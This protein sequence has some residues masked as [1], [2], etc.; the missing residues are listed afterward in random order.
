MIE[1]RCERAE[2]APAIHEILVKAFGGPCEAGLV[3]LLRERKKAE[4]ALA[5]V[6]DG[7]VVG[8]I[9][10]SRVTIARSPE[11]FS[12]IGLA[13]VAVLPEFQGKGIGSQLIR[14]GLEHCKRAGHDAVVVLGNPK[15][16]SRFGFSRAGDYGLENEYGA[17]E[18]FMVLALT[19]G[20]LDAVGGV[21]KY[22][23]EF[24]EAEESLG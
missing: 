1:I 13:P 16:Y 4:A 12:G 6:S 9:V 15:Y 3:R 19:P 5:A 14:E 24:R 20:V 17:H 11:N 18:E 10:F 21:V 7:R 23:P 2:D 8:H 22:A